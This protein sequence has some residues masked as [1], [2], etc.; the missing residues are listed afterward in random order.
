MRGGVL[1]CEES[2]ENLIKNNNCD[3]MEQVFLKLS[4]KQEEIITNNNNYNESVS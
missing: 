4:A 3:T 2:P 1:L